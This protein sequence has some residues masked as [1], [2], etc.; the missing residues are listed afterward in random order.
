MIEQDTTYEW[1]GGDKLIYALT[2]LPF[3]VAFIG[4]LYLVSTISIYLGLILVGLYLLGNVF[5]ARCCVGCPYQ[6]RYCP[7]FFGVYLAN[8]LSNTIYANRQHDA[9]I[10][11]IFAN[12]GQ[13]AVLAFLAFAAY[14]LSTLSW[15]YVLGLLALTIIHAI[16]FL[17]LLCPK[18]GY[19]ETCPA[20]KT[21]CSLFR[22]QGS[23]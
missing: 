13:L 21:A 8:I 4:A 10:Y 12:L 2:L 1:S 15:W 6:G 14:W 3:L 18:C 7:A 9:R 5:Q 23:R 20:G 22:R 17:A 11:N 16:L 19:R